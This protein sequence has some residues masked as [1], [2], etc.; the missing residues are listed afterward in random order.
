MAKLTKR[1]KE[2][3][4]YPTSE[5][6]RSVH[7][8]I[9]VPESWPVV[10]RIKHS[11]V[12]MPTKA[13][14]KR[15]RQHDPCACALALAAGRMTGIPNAAIG[16]EF[17]YIPQRD[18]RGRPFIARMEATV[19]TRKAI[20]EFDRTGTMPEGGFVF[21]PVSPAKEM[22]YVREYQAQWRRDGNRSGKTG[23]H[24]K[25]ARHMNIYD[26]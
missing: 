15:G 8:Y 17:A 22:A 12:L 24:R 11:I 25:P 10:E 1:S 20:R 3:V 14:I 9:G 23:K 13:E 26:T 16:S 18:P 5:M 7:T 21:M 19:A 4:D 6:Y 2:L